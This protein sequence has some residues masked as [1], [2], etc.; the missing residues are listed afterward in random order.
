MSYSENF[1]QLAKRYGFKIRPVSAMVNG[2]F[3]RRQDVLSVSYNNHHLMT[4]PKK[5][6][7]QP[8]P[9]YKTLEGNVQPMYYECEYKLKNW[10]YLVT[11][12]PH[13]REL[14]K[15]KVAITAQETLYENTRKIR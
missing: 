4:I 2:Q 11:R 6:Y 3:L 10:K 1:A 7:G 13:I 5:M 9:K 15:K 14:D 12:T 8:N